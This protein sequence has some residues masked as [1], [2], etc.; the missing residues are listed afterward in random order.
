MHYSAVLIAVVLPLQ[1]SSA[2]PTIPPAEGKDGG[3][4]LD[5]NAIGAVM[6]FGLQSPLDARS[7]YDLA[8]DGNLETDWDKCAVSSFAEQTD[9]LINLGGFYPVDRI[10]MLSRGEYAGAAEVFVG[11]LS[12]AGRSPK[13]FQCGGKYPDMASTSFTEFQC[14]TTFWIQ[15]IR[16]RRSNTGRYWRRWSLQICEVAVYHHS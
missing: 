14:S 6:E 5:L 11:N 4:K 16:I 2:A 9:F 13:Q 15:Y 8:I 10:A 1:F 7:S 12:D 3:E